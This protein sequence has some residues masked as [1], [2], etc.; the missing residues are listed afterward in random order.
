[1][2]ILHNWK[3][4]T[5]NA[6]TCMEC[7]EHQFY[8]YGWKKV[9]CNVYQKMVLYDMGSE[10]RKLDVEKCSYCNVGKEENKNEG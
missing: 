4:D 10:V 5:K 8:S 2:H 3:K 1:M 6:R 7:G 9:N